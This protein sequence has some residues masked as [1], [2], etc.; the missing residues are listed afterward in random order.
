MKKNKKEEVQKKAKVHDDLKG[1]ELS[2]DSFGEIQSNV[3]IDKINEFLNRNVTDK[4]LTERKE[5]VI[6]KKKKRRNE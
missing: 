1:F 2:V 6:T 3:E 4:K 5:P